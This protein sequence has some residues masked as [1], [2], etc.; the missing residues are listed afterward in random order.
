[1]RAPVCELGSVTRTFRAGASVGT[2]GRFDRLAEG[3]VRSLSLFVPGATQVVRGQVT[4]GIFYASSLLFLAMLARAVV[5]TFDRLA[6]TLDLLGQSVVFALW[7]LGI[8]FFCGAAV[9][10]AAIWAAMEPGGQI[11]RH[12]LVSGL[13]SACVPGWG[14]LLNGDRVRAVVFVGGLWLVASAWLAS[15]SFTTDLLNSHV[16][17]VSPLEQSAR[18]P[19]LLWSA[20]WTAPFLIGGLAIYDAA[21]SAAARLRQA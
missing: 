4:L 14:Q 9:H 11:P 17:I 21:A 8:A 12:P 10:L 6:L 16:P 5:G 20:K 2:P 15:S 3:V 19:F 1:M 7:T 13:A 18:A